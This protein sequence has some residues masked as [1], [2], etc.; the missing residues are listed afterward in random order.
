VREGRSLIELQKVVHVVVI[1]DALLAVRREF[2][3]IK[4]KGV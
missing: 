1:A 4:R 2:E 3:N